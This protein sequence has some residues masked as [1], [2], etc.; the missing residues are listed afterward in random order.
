MTNEDIKLAARAAGIPLWRIAQEMRISES[1]ITRRF[2]Q[3]LPVEEQ[4]RIL[5][6]IE[7]MK[8]GDEQ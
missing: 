1:T 6:L 7:Q 4:Q 3:E 5:A 8:D 2:R